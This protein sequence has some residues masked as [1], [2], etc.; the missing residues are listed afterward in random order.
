M[1]AP[2]GAKDYLL[3][4]W[5]IHAIHHGWTLDEVKVRYSKLLKLTV[6][7]IAAWTREQRARNWAK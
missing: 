6:A 4:T 3:K 2:R 7:E 1:R 5:G